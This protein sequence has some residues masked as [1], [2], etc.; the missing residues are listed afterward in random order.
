MCLDLLSFSQQLLTYTAVSPHISLGQMA[1]F[2][3]VPPVTLLKAEGTSLPA[4]LHPLPRS[5]S[6]LSTRGRGGVGGG[7][8]GGRLKEIL[9]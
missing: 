7:G 8:G 1:P 5:F 4:V 9:Q 3:L 6:L 2:T